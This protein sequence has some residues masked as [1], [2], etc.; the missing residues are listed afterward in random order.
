VDEHAD[1]HCDAAE[2]DADE[3]QGDGDHGDGDVL[4]HVVDGAFGQRYRFGEFEQVVAHEGDV[5][6]L[7]GDG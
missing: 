1:S 2:E 4:A 7:D 3:Q 6:G 5:G